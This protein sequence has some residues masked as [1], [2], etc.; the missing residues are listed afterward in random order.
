MILRLSEIDQEPDF[1][2]HKAA[3]LIIEDRKL[4]ITRTEG[5][6]IFINPGGKLAEGE[7]VLDAL[8]REHQEELS[9]TIDPDEAEFFE[10]YY[11]EA[12]YDPGMWVKLE[13]FF[14]PRWE[15]TI[16]KANEVAEIMRVDSSAIGEVALASILEEGII[17]DLV[18]KGLID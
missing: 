18:A 1:S 15:G 7:T 5:K 12:A 9:I 8:V 16:A 13:A 3:G 11:A 2:I 17:P 10:T 6:E 4:L 14:V